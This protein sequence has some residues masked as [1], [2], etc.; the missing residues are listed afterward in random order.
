[1]LD[2]EIKRLY[3]LSITIVGFSAYSSPVIFIMKVTKN[4]RQIYEVFLLTPVQIN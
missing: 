2:K 3:H 1:M 4:K